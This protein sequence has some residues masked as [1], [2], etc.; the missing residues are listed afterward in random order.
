MGYP[1]PTFSV[2]EAWNN[3]R[4]NMAGLLIPATNIYPNKKINT[5]NLVGNAILLLYFL[6]SFNLS[7]RG[8]YYHCHP[9][10][11]INP[12]MIILWTKGEY[13]VSLILSVLSIHKALSK[14]TCEKALYFERWAERA[15]RDRVSERQLA[16]VFPS[17]CLLHV[18][19]L[20]E[21]LLIIYVRN[22]FL[23][24]ARSIRREF[25]IWVTREGYGQLMFMYLE[26][27]NKYLEQM[28]LESNV[29]RKQ[30]SVFFLWINERNT[31]FYGIH[32]VQCIW[33]GYFLI[34]CCIWR[35]KTRFSPFAVV[36]RYK[37]C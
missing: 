12:Q 25:I 9:L 21:K 14:I 35:G 31:I 17:V 23:F 16:L 18:P 33:E 24:Q 7:T 8:Q 36:S 27:V 28:Q 3:G 10:S 15:T 1:G 22:A 32:N 34:I 19:L 29:S 37:F 4:S 6:N 13:N 30:A 5:L 26:K 20:M 2:I 11:I